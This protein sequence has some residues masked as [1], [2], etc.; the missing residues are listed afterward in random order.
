LI[1]QGADLERR[2]TTPVKILRFANTE[3]V[4]ALQTQFFGY[5]IS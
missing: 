2:W 1:K 3:H 4:L 5:W